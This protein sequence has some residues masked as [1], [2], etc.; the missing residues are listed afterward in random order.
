M[1]LIYLEIRVARGIR[2]TSYSGR[3]RRQFFVSTLRSWTVLCSWNRFSLH[4]PF[5][6]P[7]LDQRPAVDDL[8]DRRKGRISD[9]LGYRWKRP[10]KRKS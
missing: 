1:I 2:P 4:L 6:V 5:T 9:T 3:T 7:V 10:T 8:E